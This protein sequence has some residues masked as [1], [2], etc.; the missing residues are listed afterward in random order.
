MKE[1]DTIIKF[2]L[3]IANKELTSEKQIIVTSLYR[4]NKSGQKGHFQTSSTD[5]QMIKSF[6]MNPEHA[7]SV[8]DRKDFRF[9]YYNEFLTRST[10][11]LKAILEGELDDIFSEPSNEIIHQ[12]MGQK[13]ELLHRL[14][15]N[16]QQGETFKR[17]TMIIEQ[18]SS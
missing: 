15:I 9:L 18:N 10:R 16:P 11:L 6:S 1:I 2:S 17:I 7:W 8:G 3:N 12:I 14:K 13:G 5:H 4:V